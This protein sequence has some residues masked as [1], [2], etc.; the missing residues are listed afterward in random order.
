M[1]A[2]LS[3]ALLVTGMGVGTFICGLI[4][5]SLSLSRRMLRVLE[6]FGAGLL[7]GAA[8]TIVIPEGTKAIYTAQ[9]APPQTHVLASNS[10]PSSSSWAWSFIHKR[11]NQDHDHDHDHETFNSENVLGSAVLVGF[12][13][14]YGVH[15]LISE[16][17]HEHQHNGGNS[18]E[19]SSL[20]RPRLETHRLQR[21]PSDLNS[22]SNSKPQ[23][24]AGPSAASSEVGSDDLPADYDGWTATASPRSSA[25]L[26]RSGSSAPLLKTR[27]AS[28]ASHASAHSSH[29]SS[30]LGDALTTIIGLL[31]HAA[32]DG[33]AMGA[34]AG[35]G[36]Q[37]LTMIVFVAV[38]VHKAVSV[39]FPA[40]P[41]AVISRFF[42]HC[43]PAAFGLCTMLMGQRLS[44][45]TVRK[46]VALFSLASP[47]GALLSK[48]P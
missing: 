8:V 4:P 18:H 41:P 30:S 17:N 21:Q 9:P 34:S 26:H 14:M 3:F 37:T 11:Q 46:A 31:I 20:P 13:V 44:R 5:L 19:H 39:A 2:F 45:S 36:D 6:V 24:T 12:L 7:I 28:I 43:Q 25:S 29:L 16:H 15:Q 35:S 48:L 1:S 38:M 33:I 47:L 40:Q 27:R 42:P 23:A 22:N 10:A 32:A